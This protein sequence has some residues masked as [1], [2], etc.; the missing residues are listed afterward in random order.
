MMFL[1]FSA[2]DAD[3]FKSKYREAAEQHRHDGINFLVGD[4]E[5]SQGAF[6]VVVKD[7][8]FSS[9]L[10]EIIFIILK[11]GYSWQYFGLKQDQAPLILIQHNDAKKF[12]KPNLKPDDIATWLK[13]YKVTF[14]ALMS[15]L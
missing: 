6:Q 10:L 12:F 7:L 4:L 11:F 3:S 13:D 15:F 9:Y 8:L 1:N 2:E 14:N 5:A